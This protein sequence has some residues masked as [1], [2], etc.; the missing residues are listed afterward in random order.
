M[1]EVPT[2]C[3]DII[4]IEFTELCHASKRRATGDRRDGHSFLAELSGITKLPSRHLG[5]PFTEMGR[6]P[7][8]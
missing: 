8:A 3:N 1:S 4:G 6:L 2:F 7:V 5:D